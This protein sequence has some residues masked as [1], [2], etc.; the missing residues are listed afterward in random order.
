M[1][2]GFTKQVKSILRANGW[3]LLRAGKGD[4][5]LWAHPDA[6]KPVVID[7][8]IMSRHTANAILK[9][10]GLTDKI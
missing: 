3:Q 9:Q 5:E 4:H 7:G 1:V 2:Q 10:A 6:S 8:K